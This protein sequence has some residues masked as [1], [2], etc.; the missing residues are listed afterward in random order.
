MIKLMS[1]KSIQS[2]EGE[3]QFDLSTE[4][5]QSS[6]YKKLVCGNSGTMKSSR[7]AFVGDE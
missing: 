2:Y 3:V 6:G 1:R 4:R 5:L 7:L